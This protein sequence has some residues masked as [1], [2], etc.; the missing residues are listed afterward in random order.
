MINISKPEDVMRLLSF[1][2]FRNMEWSDYNN[3]LLVNLLWNTNLSTAADV[4][5]AMIIYWKSKGIELK[6]SPQGLKRVE[7]NKNGKYAPTNNT[8]KR[9]DYC[10]GCTDWRKCFR[11]KLIL[12]DE[13]KERIHA[14]K[15]KQS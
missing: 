9:N 3:L 12:S 2:C 1:Q 5:K 7:A 10:M 15:E 13:Y 8:M 4:Q 11:Y 6:A 14:F